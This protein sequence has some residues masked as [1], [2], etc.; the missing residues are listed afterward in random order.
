MF[1]FLRPAPLFLDR[2]APLLRKQ[3]KSA[4]ELCGGALRAEQR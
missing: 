3:L 1:S 2:S 4:P